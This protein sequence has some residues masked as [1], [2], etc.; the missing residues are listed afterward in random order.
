MV[1]DWSGAK[2]AP[3]DTGGTSSYRTPD[4]FSQGS[5]PRGPGNNSSVSIFYP[6]R[7]VRGIVPLVA[8]LVLAAPAGAT[9]I[10]QH[11]AAEPKLVRRINHVRA[12]HGLK[13]L[14]VV[15]RL[16][17]GRDEN[18]R[19]RWRR[20]ATSATS[21]PQG[22]VEVVRNMDTLVL[23][24]PGLHV[25]ERRREPRLGSAG[26]RGPQDRVSLDAQPRPPGEPAR[27]DV[28]PGR[29]LGRPRHRPRRDVRALFGGDDR[30]R[31]LRQA[32]PLT[33][34]A[35]ASLGPVGQRCK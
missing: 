28:E 17:T 23:A 4:R 13:P 10:F 14:H 15:A 32:V 20:S 19:T 21:P 22:R 30:H 16:S 24:R 7:V 1:A 9:A 8:A 3:L 2:E 27:Q 29:R 35:A 6:M 11:D 18:T 25:L 26:P 34:W 5:L 12:N 33:A 31:R